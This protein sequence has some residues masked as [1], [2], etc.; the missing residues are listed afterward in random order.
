M[1]DGTCPS[2][3]E[4]DGDQ[5]S[6]VLG[7]A[8]DDDI[9][10]SLQLIQR[11]LEGRDPM[12][13][14]FG[15]SIVDVRDVAL[16]HVRALQRDDS[17]G[18]RFIGSERF[19]WMQEIAQLLAAEYPDR[20]IPQRAAPDVLVRAMGLFDKT[21]RTSVVPLL[22]RAHQ[23]SNEAACEVLE[24]EFTEARH[25]IRT[26]AASLIRAELVD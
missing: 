15:M 18:A 20:K 23:L 13:P 19:M 5:P 8:L 12:V 10:T 11:V 2:G 7:P 17:I 1:G 16:M 25:A 26:A 4:S 21:I 22:G 9:G 3:V 6:L 24:I 14:N